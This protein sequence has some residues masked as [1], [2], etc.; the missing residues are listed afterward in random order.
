MQFTCAFQKLFFSSFLQSLT[1]NCDQDLDTFLAQFSND[2]SSSSMLSNQP[3]TLDIG[4]TDYHNNDVNS[5]IIKAIEFVMLQVTSLS[6]PKQARLGNLQG[7][8]SCQ[9]T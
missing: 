4:P 8:V 5:S 9:P 1:G 6:N 7:Q 3:N 2:K